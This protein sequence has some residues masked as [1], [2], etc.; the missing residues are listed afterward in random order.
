MLFRS[1]SEVQ[2]AIEGG[3]ADA[4]KRGLLARAVVIP[5]LDARLRARL[6]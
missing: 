2:A 4:Q 6:L 3:R 5:R 1:V